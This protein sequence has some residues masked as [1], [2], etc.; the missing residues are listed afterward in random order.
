LNCYFRQL[1]SISSRIFYT[2]IGYV[3]AAN[4]WQWI[5]GSDWEFC[6]TV[7]TTNDA[8]PGA[9][10][11]SSVNFTELHLPNIS[12]VD[13]WKA[14]DCKTPLPAIY[15]CYLPTPTQIPTNTLTLIMERT[16]VDTVTTG[17]IEATS[18]DSD[19]VES[20]LNSTK[21]KKTKKHKKHLAVASD[22]EG[23]DTETTTASTDTSEETIQAKSR[24]P[25]SS[26]KM[27]QLKSPK[28]PTK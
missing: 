22:E 9:C 16:V 5:D 25:M 21:M 28:L 19:T 6:L 1:G 18:S 11:Q 7:N 20:G 15:K 10:L 12:S 13:H 17:S 26:Q 23:D 14:S 2:F 4:D 27:A 8:P 24:Q 3:N